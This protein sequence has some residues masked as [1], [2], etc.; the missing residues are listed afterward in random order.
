MKT[1]KQLQQGEKQA[2]KELAGLPAVESYGGLTDARTVDFEAF[3]EGPRRGPQPIY[4]PDLD[5][6]SPFAI[7]S[8]FWTEEMWQHLA[9]NTNAYAA[10]QGAVERGSNHMGP[11]Q[12]H[13]NN[14]T[15]QRAW[16][17][18][19]SDE[20]KVFI[21]ALIY[22]DIHPEYEIADYWNR[23]IFHGPTHT[24]SRWI[25]QDRFTQLQ[26]FLDCNPHLYTMLDHANNDA[27]KIAV[28]AP[29]KY[30]TKRQRKD[31]RTRLFQ[32]LFEF[33]RRGEEARQT[34]ML[35]N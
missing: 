7:F 8:L 14:A 20:L 25:T 13:D 1:A 5:L 34:S 11:R 26:R 33:S 35:G 28:D 30:W 15:N 32:E 6:D 10:R 3:K 18:T 22:M 19:L 17:A 27:F 2:E 24:L 12:H 16:S 31:F 23:D 29:G 21:G 9:M 4:R